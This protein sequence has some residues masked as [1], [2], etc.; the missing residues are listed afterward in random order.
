MHELSIAQNILEIVNHYVPSEKFHEVKA[1]KLR[2][3]A[4]A[5]VVAESLEFSFQVLTRNTPLQTSQLEITHIPFSLQCNACGKI[6]TNDSG[7]SICGECGKADTRILSGT[8]LDI[9]EIEL[10]DSAT[11]KP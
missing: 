2:I 10:F 1:V 11:E 8:E 9:T 6:S 5:G 7:V 3:G 4:F